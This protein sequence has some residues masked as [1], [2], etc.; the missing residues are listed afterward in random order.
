LKHGGKRKEQR[1]IGALQGRFEAGK[2]TFK[3]NATD[4]TRVLQS[5]LVDFPRGK[6]DDLIDALA[7]CEQLGFGTLKPTKK[8]NYDN[9]YVDEML[10][11][12][13]DGNMQVMKSDWTQY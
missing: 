2:I 9:P 1:I 12:I 10:E 13:L 7:Y 4:D 6:N 8:K 5:E 11:D 3:E